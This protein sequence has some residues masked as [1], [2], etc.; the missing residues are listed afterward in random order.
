MKNSKFN[1][2]NLIDILIKKAT[3][4]YYTEE[5]YEYEKSQNKSKLIQNPIQNVSFFENYDRVTQN[6]NKSNDTIKTSD[7]RNKINEENQILT[8]SKKKVTSHYISPD[9]N[10]IKILYEI[11]EKEVDENSLDNLSDKELIELNNKLK[12]E[13]LDEINKN[14]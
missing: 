7:E 12:E 11:F 9:I 4:Y 6:D 14:K 5:Q 13:L 1:K 3:G 2:S 10:A 8:L